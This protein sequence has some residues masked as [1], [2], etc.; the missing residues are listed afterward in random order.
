M[1]TTPQD[2]KQLKNLSATFYPC[3]GEGLKQYYEVIGRHT[4]SRLEKLLEKEPYTFAEDR[5]S[6]WMMCRMR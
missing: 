3:T 6:T 5:K 2:L 1:K 4:D